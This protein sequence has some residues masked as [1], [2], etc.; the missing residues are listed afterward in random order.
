MRKISS[1]NGPRPDPATPAVSESG[2]SRRPNLSTRIW[3]PRG[4]FRPIPSQATRSSTRSI[5][6]ARGVYQAVQKG[7]K[8][9][10]AIKVMKEGR[11]PASGTRLASSE[12]WRFSASS[13]TRTSSRSTTAAPP[14]AIS[15]YAMDYIPGQPL[16]VYMTDKTTAPLDKGGMGVVDQRHLRLF[17]DLR[18]GQRRPPSRR[19]P[20]RPEAWNIRLTPRRADILDSGWRSGDG[21][22]ASA[23]TV[24]GQFVGSCRGRA[25][26][27][28]RSAEQDRHS[29]DVYSSV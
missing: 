11:S 19:H 13:A 3:Q 28:G 6:V 27:G 7:T 1:S 23:M 16:D 14:R 5:A 10:V 20:P 2:T 17:E 22:E 9:K 8:R 4:R 24:T 26:A 29:D 21:T 25:R 12:K 18:G 15:T